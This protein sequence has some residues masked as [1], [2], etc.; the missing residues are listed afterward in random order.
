LHKYN[1]VEYSIKK[2]AI[3]CFICYLFK[4]KKDKGKGTDAFTV[5]DWRNWN[6]GEK[7]LLTHMGSNAHK[8]A[9]KKYIGFTNSDAQIDDK[10]EKW[11]DEDHH[12]YKIR[13]TY[14][15][16]YIKF[17]LHQGL[18][19]C[20]HNESEESSNRGN[21]IELLK[22]LPSNSKEVDKYV[23][24]NA[25]SNCSL[26]SP[27]IQ[28][29]V[30][31]CC[32]IETRKKI[33][34][35][36]GDEPYAILADEFSDISYKEQLALCLC[37]VDKLGRPCERFIGVVKVDDTPLYHLRKQLKLYLLAMA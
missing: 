12:L 13:L 24:K 37:Y 22:F 28:K 14:T 27:K 20:G 8:A 9:H 26:T 1:W 31:Q 10:I 16:R 29:Q 7:A 19:F 36:L 35:E 4:D 34:D 5:Q 30:I 17:L 33:I 25:P 6:I 32:A 23:L 3:F 15:L 2:D 18:A 21:F 11:S